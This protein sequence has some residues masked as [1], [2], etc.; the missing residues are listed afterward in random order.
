M[1]LFE[2]DRTEEQVI[3]RSFPKRVQTTYGQY[4]LKLSGI[5]ENIFSRAGA[6]SLLPAENQF[7]R[8]KGF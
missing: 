8:V 2:E 6:T 7:G 3:E 4:R 1:L 5:Y